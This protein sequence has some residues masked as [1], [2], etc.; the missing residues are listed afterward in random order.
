MPQR[1]GIV[2]ATVTAVALAVA[3]AGGC[4]SDRSDAVPGTTGSG[5]S[6]SGVPASPP[7][8]A[9][10]PAP[11]TPPGTTEGS[12]DPPT[13]DR[14]AGDLCARG[15]TR[16]EGRV[17]SPLLDEASGLVA[18]R[19]HDGVLWSHND[20][21]ELPGLF[22]VGDDGADLGLHLLEV[23]GVVDVEDVAL[24]AGPDGGVDHLL[25]ADIGD[26]RRQRATIRLYRVAEPDPAAPA[27]LR[28][29]EIL[30][31]A[32]P[33]GPHNA[34]VLL[35]DEA[36][37]SVVIVTKEQLEV[38][39]VPR[40]LGPTAPSFVFEG[41]LDGHGA[42]PVTLDLVGTI[43]MPELE[44]RTVAATPHP[45]SILGN[46]GVPTGGDVSADGALVA[47]RTYETVWVWPREPGRRVAE[48]FT[49]DPCQVLL[50]PESQGEAIAFD[51]D[52]LVSV[53]EGAGEPIHR[54]VP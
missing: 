51:G 8:T 26:N 12:V 39:G 4:G 46:G 54:V 29:V 28:Q 11:P 53:S 5:A 33:D 13:P 16:V 1:A 19:T 15:T 41:P 43:D 25:L 14:R 35:V 31:F 49:G 23:G 22:A 50:A 36:A 47:L 18:S 7:P 37:R 44:T 42:G 38:D 32:Y 45:T 3:L 30:E 6:S 2:P 24:L 48:A 40:D 34:E 10:D 27:P 9:T 21:A 20:G 17:A 52:D